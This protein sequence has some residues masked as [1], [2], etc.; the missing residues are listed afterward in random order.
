MVIELLKDYDNNFRNFIKE[1][2]EN[3]NTIIANSSMVVSR[4]QEIESLKKEIVILK[5]QNNGKS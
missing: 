3:I 4:D 1:V 2:N 5:K